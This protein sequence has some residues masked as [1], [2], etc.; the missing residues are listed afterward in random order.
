MGPRQSNCRGTGANWRDKDAT[1]STAVD[2]GIGGQRGCGEVTQG[3]K[4]VLGR[5]AEAA[6]AHVGHVAN[7]RTVAADV[8]GARMRSLKEEKQCGKV[9]R[10]ASGKKGKGWMR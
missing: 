10:R 8:I 9:E 4:A 3:A 1:E 5:H 6:L 2:E 7:A